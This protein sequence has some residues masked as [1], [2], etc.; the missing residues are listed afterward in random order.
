MAKPKSDQVTARLA[1]PWPDRVLCL[2]VWGTALLVVAFAAWLLGDLVANGWSRIDWA[3]LTQ[4]PARFGREGGIL[5]ILQSTLMILL[6]C[7]AVSVPLG[8]A[9]ALLLAEFS[10]GASRVGS[11]I[12]ASL[13]L[14]AGVPS[15]VF[16]L[17]GNAFFCVTLGLGYSILSGGLTLACMVLP[18]FIRSVEI[19]LRAV[20][21][22]Y[23]FAG[24]ALAMSRTSMIRNVLLPA[25][26]PG[27]MAGL[28]LGIGRAMAETAALMYTSGYVPRSPTSLMDSGRTI[29]LHIH[30]LA[31]NVSGGESSAYA[32]ALVLVFLLLIINLCASW[33]VERVVARGTS[34][35]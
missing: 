21:K 26:A 19:G 33:L 2:S 9:T 7:L 25:A 23:R 30:E 1:T 4:A 18:I 10:A 31:I 15:I 12:R 35:A 6:V 32:S 22:D 13:D 17:F 8:T 16:G 5:P 29:S 14:L 11:V 3:F 27:I 34:A 20:P 24:A 28:M